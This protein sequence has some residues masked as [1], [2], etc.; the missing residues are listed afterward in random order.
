MPEKP[1]WEWLQEHPYWSGAWDIAEVEKKKAVAFLVRVPK[2]EAKVS[3]KEKAPA[4][5]KAGLMSYRRVYIF[6]VM[7]HFM[8][9]NFIAEFWFNY[10]HPEVKEAVSLLATQPYL[11]LAFHDV[12]PTPLRFYAFPNDL[13]FDIVIMEKMLKEAK[14]WTDPEFDEAKAAIQAKYTTEELWEAL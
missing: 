11:Y 14:P 12:G 6:I 7:V 9:L 8:P 2:E 3:P 4:H 10:I 5:W 13:K 1:I